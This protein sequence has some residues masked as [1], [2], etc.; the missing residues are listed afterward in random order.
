[1]C[2]T[3]QGAPYTSTPPPQT[4]PTCCSSRSGASLLPSMSLTVLGSLPRRPAP[5]CR[6][7]W[8]ASSAALTDLGGRRQG[9]ARGVRGVCVAGGGGGGGGWCN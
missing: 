7:S 1:V 5:R 3:S 8:N 6:M 4:S 2:H 9:K